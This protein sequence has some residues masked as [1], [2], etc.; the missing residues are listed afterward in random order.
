LFYSTLKYF[1]YLLKAQN[2]HGLHSP[3]VYKLYTEIIRDTSN[4]DVYN[5]VE[6][7]RN[8]LLNNNS[9]FEFTDYGAKGSAAGAKSSKVI[10]QT[11]KLVL[12]Q[13]KYAQL[14][15]RLAHYLKPK[16][17]LE[18]GSSFGISTRYQSLGS[19]DAEFY[20]MEGCENTLNIAKTNNSNIHWVLGNFD[21]TLAETLSKQ[22][23]F[24]WIYMDGNHAY[25]PTMRYFKQILPKTNNNTIL[26]MDDIYWSKE[27]TKAWE[28]I[29]TNDLVT[30]TIDLYA[31]GIVFFRKEQVK[32]HFV[33][34]Y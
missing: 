12:K 19:P 7:K 21:N 14:L 24:D 27:M 26:I 13:P 28:E 30:V 15:Y 3:F 34:R 2:Q 5:Q 17:M 20:S 10:S 29:K 8:A 6:A 25:E 4:K 16:T 23:S 31:F 1:Q 22:E 33:L 18:L 32:E 9:T 11:A